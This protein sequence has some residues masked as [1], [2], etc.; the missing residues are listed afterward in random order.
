MKT[1]KSTKKRILLTVVILLVIQALAA[2]PTPGV[3]TEYFK[4]LLENNTSAGL[5][6]MM[7]GN[8]LS[9][10]SITMLSITPYIT[11]SIILQLLVVVYRP[12]EEMQKDGEVGK[13]KFKRLTM[14]VGAFL[15]I[16]EAL[17][18]AI[19]F[20]KQGL[21]ISYKVPW[22]LCVTIIWTGMAILLM[23]SGE[24][25]EKN[26]F[27]N[28]ISLILLCNILTSYPSDAVSVY[29]RFLHGYAF[30]KIV[31]SAIIIG[32]V[33]LVLFTFT[34]YIQLIEKRI[35]V[36][37]AAKSGIVGENRSFFPIKLC[38]G[39]VVPVIF[40]SSLMSM[41]ALIATLINK[42]CWVI[43]ML[44]STKWFDPK[45]PSY[46]T[47]VVL[48]VALIFAFSYFYTEMILNPLE[49]ANNLKKSGGSFP[50]IRPGQ[51][52]IDYL[53]C[54][55]RKTIAL[56]AVALSVIAL[57]PCVLSGIF[58]LSKL[59]FAGTS[60]I[61]IVGVIVETAERFKAENSMKKLELI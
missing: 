14:V 9:N 52:T 1:K 7:S 45:H 54:E 26:G 43:D 60:I 18:F 61:I 35:P 27:G 16:I 29:E 40:A 44:N 3:N 48:Y 17:G 34:T 42:S 56:G 4:E 51:E 31:V 5:L 32:L 13:Q 28:G 30:N 53:T 49:I 41:P 2:I 6:N 58:G 21:L 46:T 24:Y 23:L 50:N 47:G 25:I 59:S 38:P 8:G 37:Y 19:G 20:G 15:A 11:A 36:K 39:T 12:L 33:V 22:I 10:L 55:M 57:V